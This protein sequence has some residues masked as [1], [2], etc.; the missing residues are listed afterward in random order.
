M[1]R[2]DSQDAGHEEG[3]NA[4]FQIPET[5]GDL[6]LHQ[7]SSFDISTGNHQTA[8]SGMRSVARRSSINIGSP[9]PKRSRSAERT[10]RTYGEEIHLKHDDPHRNGSRDAEERIVN[11]NRERLASDSS[12]SKQMQSHRRAVSD[13][14]DNAEMDGISD[15][16]VD[17]PDLLQEKQFALPTLQ[18]F[19]FAETHNRNCWSEPPVDIFQVRGGDYLTDKKKVTARKY[20]LRAR[21]CDLFLAE[22]PNDCDMAR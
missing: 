17:D 19:P 8:M 14:F 7:L 16:H 18:R 3:V 12:L 20:L 6:L 21:G 2:V 13:P 22:N 10:M 9:E 15:G 5:L 11:G 4:L 1:T